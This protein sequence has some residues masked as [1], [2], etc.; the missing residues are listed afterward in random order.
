MK[1]ANYRQ[2]RVDHELYGT[3]RETDSNFRIADDTARTSSVASHN[4][5]SE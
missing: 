2:L 4:A 1:A 3:Y 5:V